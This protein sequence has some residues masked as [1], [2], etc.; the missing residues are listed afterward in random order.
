MIENLHNCIYKINRQKLQFWHTII[1]TPLHFTM[2]MR[3]V[4]AALLVASAAA[5]DVKL[6]DLQCNERFP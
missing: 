2:M 6:R 3:L 1:V 5:L 4:T